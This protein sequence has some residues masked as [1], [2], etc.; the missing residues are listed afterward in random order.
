[1]IEGYQES[2][3]KKEKEMEERAKQLDEKE[4]GMKKYLEEQE[5][6]MKGMQE[7]AKQL[8]EK[9]VEMKKYSEEQKKEMRERREEVEETRITL[10]EEKRE[11]EEEKERVKKTKTFEKTI[12]LN[13]GGSKYTTTL[14][15]LTKYPDSMLGAMF[16]GRHALVQQEDGSYFIDRDGETFRYILMYLRDDRLARAII[17]KL[18]TKLLL[19]L[20]HDAEYFQLP[21]LAKLSKVFGE[22]GKPQRWRK[23]VHHNSLHSH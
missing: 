23:Q 6:E 11:W 12:N 7:R 10:A 2:A 9:E 5:K 21:E 1:M 8:D 4:A 19:H 22:C 18:D 20:A 15:T 14:S 13:I 3:Q 16:S 17:P